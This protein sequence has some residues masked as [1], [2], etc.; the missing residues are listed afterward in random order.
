MRPFVSALAA[1]S[2]A[3]AP[4]AGLAQQPV[5]AP[6]PAQAP[7]TTPAPA[8]QPAPPAEQKKEAEKPSLVENLGG[9]VGGILA[10]SAASATGG[11]LAGAA[12]NRGLQGQ[13]RVGQSGAE[14]I[15]PST[16]MPARAS[17]VRRTASTQPCVKGD[18]PA[19]SWEAS[20]AS[21]SVSGPAMWIPM[22]A[23]HSS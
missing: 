21:K 23:A 8:A 7:A 14:R 1:T 17:T 19:H 5:P 16:S 9:A 10:S 2:I 20:S 18:A 4:A 13:G 12:R 3:F 11:P 15:V 6:D 22:W